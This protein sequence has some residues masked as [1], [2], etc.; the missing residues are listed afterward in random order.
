MLSD[1]R[2]RR[3]RENSGRIKPSN[4]VLANSVAF[5]ART[6]SSRENGLSL[7]YPMV[8]QDLESP[9]AYSEDFSGR[10]PI[11]HRMTIGSINKGWYNYIIKKNSMIGNTIS[12]YAPEASALGEA[13]KVLK[14]LSEARLI[15]PI[16]REGRDDLFRNFEGTDHGW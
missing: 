11:A 8:N 13:D 4:P 3:M 1:H 2:R 15:V 9:D 10:F 14:K 12:H 5:L 6:V 7:T 16:V